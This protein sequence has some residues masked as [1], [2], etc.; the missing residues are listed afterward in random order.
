MLGG[1]LSDSED[2][3]E[4]EEE[5]SDECGEDESNHR[6]NG[7]CEG[8]SSTN[9]NRRRIHIPAVSTTMDQDQ[10]QYQSQSDDMNG[11]WR[12]ASQ[13][14]NEQLS[15]EHKNIPTPSSLSLNKTHGEENT[16]S[17]ANPVSEN[18]RQLSNL[19]R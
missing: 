1:I 16:D 18:N 9:T 15:L 17:T 10:Y 13:V 19:P 5:D 7:S 12:D 14:Q 3:D 6:C 8:P 11:L 4:E 2:D